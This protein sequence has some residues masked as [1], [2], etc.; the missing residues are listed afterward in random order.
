MGLGSIV[1]CSFPNLLTGRRRKS[2]VL[3][4]GPF[5]V[6]MAGAVP[7]WS[8]N[9]FSENRLNIRNSGPLGLSVK[10]RN[11]HVFLL[12]YYSD[13]NP[14]IYGGTSNT[15]GGGKIIPGFTFFE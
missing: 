15:A 5:V 13:I 3:G 6:V 11:H 8:G 14:S 2:I 4:R 7:A 9:A 12:I 10:D 1:R